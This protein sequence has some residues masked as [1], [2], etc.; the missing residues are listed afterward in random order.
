[1]VKL[2]IKKVIL[3]L[4]EENQYYELKVVFNM[5]AQ[6]YKI[7]IKQF[8]F[9]GYNYNQVVD[10][11]KDNNIGKIKNNNV[12]LLKKDIWELFLNIFDRIELNDKREK[13][14]KEKYQ[15]VFNNNIKNLSKV[16]MSSVKDK[17]R[18]NIDI[19]ILQKIL[20][21]IFSKNLGYIY[22][23]GGKENLENFL[24]FY[25]A[26]FNEKKN[27]FIIEVGNIENII[28][29]SYKYIEVWK[30][31]YYSISDI[32][33]RLNYPANIDNYYI[34]S[35]GI[36]HS[37]NKWIDYSTSGIQEI[38]RK[39][40][41]GESEF[42]K[43]GN[44]KIYGSDEQYKDAKGKHKIPVERS[45]EIRPKGHKINKGKLQYLMNSTY[46]RYLLLE[47]EQRIL[48][49]NYKYPLTELRD[50]I[51]TLSIKEIINYSSGILIELNNQYEENIKDI[52]R[53]N[54]NKVQNYEYIIKTI[55]EYRKHNTLRKLEGYTKLKTS[56]NKLKTIKYKAPMN[57]ILTNI[58]TILGNNDKDYVTK[59][60]KKLYNKQIR[61]NKNEEK[62][63]NNSYKLQGEC[64]RLV[65]VIKKNLQ[66][67]RK[68]LTQDKLNVFD[69]IFNDIIQE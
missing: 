29:E 52:I 2:S 51:R 40:Y 26:G 28:N 39:D 23:D 1:M 13:L 46:C 57:D 59:I 30:E 25:S 35:S 37:K 44:W 64:S 42:F 4:F 38:V 33:K 12:L 20:D 21:E 7:N 9:V 8:T 32:K 68:T 17:S 50:T 62:F 14:S 41:E 45:L 43:I 47:L 61:N 27:K 15:D 69:F 63:R 24:K 58:E 48:H 31:K 5:F 6:Y 34:N 19:V 22:N 60:S 65:E 56:I 53:D 66:Q 55:K 16:L 18:I 10:I 67:H 11:A 54:N 49:E 36:Y 3:D